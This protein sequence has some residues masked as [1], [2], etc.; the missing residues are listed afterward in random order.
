MKRG[1]VVKQIT[2]DHKPGELSERSRIQSNGGQIA[3]SKRFLG[4]SPSGLGTGGPLRVYPGGLTVSRSFGDIGAKIERLGG[5]PGVIIATP[6]LFK[7]EILGESDFIV[8]GSDGLYDRLKN[9]EIVQALWAVIRKK[10]NSKG[11]GSLSL[12]ELIQEGCADEAIVNLAMQ[13]HSLD[14]ITAVVIAL[15]GLKN[16]LENSNQP[17]PVR[18][19]ENLTRKPNGSLGSIRNPRILF[20]KL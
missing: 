15:P 11:T 7:E 13:K 17:L 6:E 10:A 16:F 20:K 2:K 1:S 18:P 12:E 3:S 8:I 9:E 19:C 5:Q 4:I 14:N